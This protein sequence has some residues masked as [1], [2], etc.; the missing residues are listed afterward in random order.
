MINHPL[1]STRHALQH[2]IQALQES[3]AAFAKMLG[4]A[5]R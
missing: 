3:L 5:W 1:D 2:A 4:R